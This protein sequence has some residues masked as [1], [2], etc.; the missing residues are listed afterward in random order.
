MT[1]P[2]PKPKKSLIKPTVRDVPYVSALLFQIRCYV[3]KYEE[4]KWNIQKQEYDWSKPARSPKTTRHRKI[5]YSEENFDKDIHLWGTFREAYEAY[6]RSQDELQ[7]VGFLIEP[8]QLHE[9][10]GPTE[11]DFGD[12]FEV[13]SDKDFAIYCDFDDCRN[14]YTGEIHPWVEEQI[15]KQDTYAEVS[16]SGKGIRTIGWGKRHPD[17][18]TVFPKELTDGLQ[19][20]VYGGAVGKRHLITFTGVPLEGRRTVPMRNIQDWIDTVVPIKENHQGAVTPEPLD[21]SDKEILQKMLSSKDGELIERF[22]AGDENLWEGGGAKYSSRSEA[23]QGF[24]RKLAFWARGDRARMRRIAV[25]S[26]MQRPKWESE[27]YLNSTIQHGIEFCRGNFYDPDYSSKDDLIEGFIGVWLGLK[28]YERRRSFGA[29]LARANA[30]G[31]YTREG[32][33]ISAHSQQHVVPEE[34]LLVYASLR[35][36]GVWMG[37]SDVPFISRAMRRLN[38]EGLVTRISEGRGSKGSLYL[39]PTTLLSSSD[40]GRRGD[41]YKQHRRETHGAPSPHDSYKQHRRE[42]HAAPAAA[43]VSLLCCKSESNVYLELIWTQKPKEGT[44]GLTKKQKLL[45]ELVLFGGISSVEGVAEFLGIRK[46]NLKSRVIKQVEEMGLL[47]CDGDL[48][49][50]TGDFEE[51]L[52]EVFVESGGERALK[53]AQ[54][55]FCQDR[56]KYSEEGQLANQRSRSEEKIEAALRG[57]LDWAELSFMELFE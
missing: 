43:C 2:Q 51:A 10:H 41:S 26:K 56:K 14:P 50:M 28:D 49:K 48:L 13:P 37:E 7:G 8:D 18:Y 29:I 4:P 47:T 19:V 36:Q 23:D 9:V 25:S 57:E 1:A 12:P 45:I 11:F 21:F 20:E 52:H 5:R 33:R 27:G 3:W 55:R 22:M 42:T 24:F 32:Y 15:E 54:E 17:S 16:P 6:E 44:K 35:A 46:N 40:S 53:S 34:G 31:W 38:E 39:I 30:Y